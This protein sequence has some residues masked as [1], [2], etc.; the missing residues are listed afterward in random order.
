MLTD[1]RKHFRCDPMFE[2]LGRG[3]F[4]GQNQAVKAGFVNNGHVLFTAK[5]ALNWGVLF[6]IIVNMV[7]NGF[8][9][10]AVPQHGSNILTD[11]PRF[12]IQF[13]GSVPA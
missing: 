7:T 5:G 3:K 10:I 1:G 6:V 13:N 12:T 4:A 9:W 2:L 11:K 8:L